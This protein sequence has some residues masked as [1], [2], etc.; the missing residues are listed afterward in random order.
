MPKDI[1][2]FYKNKHHFINIER[3]SV[4]IELHLIGVEIVSIAIE[5]VLVAIE[6]YFAEADNNPLKWKVKLNGIQ[7]IKNLSQRTTLR[8]VAQ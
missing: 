3:V 4:A 2:F 7:R 5:R 8:Y 6:W 1:H